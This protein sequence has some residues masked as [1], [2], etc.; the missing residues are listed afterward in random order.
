MKKCIVIPDSY[1]GTLSSIEVCKIMKEYV[2]NYYPKCNVITIPIAD[3]GEGTVDCFLYALNAKKVFVDTTGPYGE[4]LS[5][6]YAKAEDTAIIE[7][8]SAAGLPLVQNNLDPCKTTTYGV[9]T[10]VRNAVESGCKNIV[11]G[12]GGSC[13]NDGGVGLARALGTKFYNNNGME[14]VPDAD[15]LTE[16]SF[17]DNSKTQELLKDCK[18]TA[19]CDIDNPMYGKTGAAYIFAPQKGADLETVE[20]LDKNLRALADVIK[21]SL[22]KDVADLPGAGAAGALGAGI[23]GFLN[24]KLKSGIESILDLI[25]FDDILDNTDMIFTG[26]GRIDSQSLR[27]KV[28]IGVAGRAKKK[29]IPVTA[30]VG[31]IGEGANGAY[32]MGVNAIFSINQTTMAF[33]EARCLS[34][35]NLAKTMNSIIRFYKTVHC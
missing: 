35:V 27:G 10:L 28:I 18:I 7:M 6:Y 33:E 23:V 12:L 13:T 30:V 2:L 20:L 11:L 21:E 29:N 24:G 26:E 15:K 31:S 32:D 25:H 17:I 34:N 16:I 3:G 22:H 4:P 14:F 9:G 8:A 19:M 1:K 5:V